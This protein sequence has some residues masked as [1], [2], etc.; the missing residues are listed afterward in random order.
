M[1][2]EIEVRLLSSRL[3]ALE[4]KVS[5]QISVLQTQ[6]IGKEEAR[7]LQAKEYERRL[8]E[9]KTN[10]RFAQEKTLELD[11]WRRSID[12]WRWISIGAGIAGGGL[13]AWLA[14]LLGK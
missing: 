12:Q 11:N 4:L 10:E 13:A 9:L 3:E 2:D 6:V 1:C 7:S 8:E 5:N 14:R